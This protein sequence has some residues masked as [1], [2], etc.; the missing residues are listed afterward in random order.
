MIDHIS[1][2]VADLS[3]SAD[4]YDAV[5]APLGLGLLVR[6]TGRLGYGKAYPEFWLNQRRSPPTVPED[7]GQHVCLRAPDR[8]AVLAFHRI[9][10]AKG[11]RCDGPPGE[12]QASIT[13][14][15]GAFVRD[16]D[17]NRIEAVTFPKPDSPQPPSTGA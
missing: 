13:V 15:F 5:L 6:E 12:R 16:S 9:A 10:L 4:F 7:S 14:Y 1:L 11:G 3:R 2:V 17:G 8:A